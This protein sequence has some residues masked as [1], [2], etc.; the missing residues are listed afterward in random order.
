MPVQDDQ[1][2]DIQIED[3][4]KNNNNSNNKHSSTVPHET[5]DDFDD[6]MYDMTAPNS[7]PQGAGK[8]GVQP[9]T[10]LNFSG[11]TIYVDE[12]GNQKDAWYR[13]EELMKKKLEKSALNQLKTRIAQQNRQAG[14]GKA[15]PPI[16]N[17]GNNDSD[18][19]PTEK[20]DPEINTGASSAVNPT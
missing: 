15:P 18:M 1:F 19:E 17:D 9:Q 6:V 10:P 13:E 11:N 4:P 20:P 8:K 16:D 12:K 7:K 2:I 14:S 3:P 5:T